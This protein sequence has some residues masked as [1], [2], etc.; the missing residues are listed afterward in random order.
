MKKSLVIGASTDPQRYS[1]KAVSM[2]LER[3]NPVEAIGSEKGKICGVNIYCD[4]PRFSGIDTINMY[5]NRQ[6]QEKFYD[7]ILELNPKRVIFNPGTENPHLYSLLS[8][9][10]IEYDEACT[11]IMLSRDRY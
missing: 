9:Y 11:L 4:Q 8:K 3:N 6:T 2:L 10:N 5:I 7:Y 1:F